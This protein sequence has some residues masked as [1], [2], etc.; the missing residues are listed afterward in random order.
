MIERGVKKDKGGN[1]GER[2]RKRD[3]TGRIGGEREGLG[4]RERQTEPVMVPEPSV[5]HSLSNL[6]I[7]LTIIKIATIFL[8]SHLF[9]YIL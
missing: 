1:M 3:R 8:N 2:L 9:S 6:C 4:A 7:H 5:A